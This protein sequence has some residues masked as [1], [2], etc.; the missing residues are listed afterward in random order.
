[1]A[2]FF[3]APLAFLRVREGASTDL[4]AFASVEALARGVAVVMSRF[5]GDRWTWSHHRRM[6]VDYVESRRV[7]RLSTL[8]EADTVWR[9]DRR[10][11]VEA[12]GPRGRTMDMEVL[13]S[14]GRAILEAERF[15]RRY[16]RWHKQP[17]SGQGPVPGVSNTRGRG[18]WRRRI[19][20]RTELRLNALVVH[21]EGEVSARA[22][23][24]GTNLPDTRDG[25]ARD[26]QR[27]WKAQGKGRKAWDRG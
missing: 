9:V 20:T 5:E 13:L 16:A 17:Y 22:S 15:A 26:P 7:L 19:H 12:Y 3:C 1:M 25:Y 10:F 2:S 14:Q 27:S 8:V 11:E 4:Q 18:R 6:V 23:R 21:E 24:C